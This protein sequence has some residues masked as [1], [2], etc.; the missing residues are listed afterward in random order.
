[1][2]EPFNFIVPKVKAK[3]PKVIDICATVYGRTQWVRFP[4]IL[5]DKQV[6]FIARTFNRNH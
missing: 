5:D 3:E 2:E 6:D 1:M 4:L